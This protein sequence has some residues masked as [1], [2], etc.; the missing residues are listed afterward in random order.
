MAEPAPEASAWRWLH[1]E[2]RNEA[3]AIGSVAL[4]AKVIL[5]LAL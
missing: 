2:E 3:E 5:T 4:D 1:L